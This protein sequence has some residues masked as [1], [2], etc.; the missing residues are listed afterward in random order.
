MISC[1]RERYGMLKTEYNIWIELWPFSFGPQ[2]LG[3]QDKNEGKLRNCILI[4]LNI[5]I[6]ELN[7]NVLPNANGVI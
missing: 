3:G 2:D 1:H 6:F 5:Q 4:T 7:R